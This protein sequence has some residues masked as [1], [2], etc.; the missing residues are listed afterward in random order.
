MCSECGSAIHA[1]TLTDRKYPVVALVGRSNVGKSTLFT[2]IAGVHRK[3]GNWPSTTVEVGSAEVALADRTITL[4]DLPGTASIHPG[5]PD[6][7]TYRLREHG[8]LSLSAL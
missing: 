8:S 2:R 6:C 1:S 7:I 5:S 4:L 3:M